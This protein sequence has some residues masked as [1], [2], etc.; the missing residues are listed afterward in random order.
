MPVVLSAV[1][2]AVV[3]EREQAQRRV[4][5]VAARRRLARRRA[6][7]PGRASVAGRR[8]RP[9]PAADGGGAGQGEAGG[10]GAWRGVRRGRPRSLLGGDRRRPAALVTRHEPAGALPTTGRAR[11]PV[12]RAPGERAGGLQQGAGAERHDPAVPVVRLLA[13]GV[14]AHGDRE[15]LSPALTVSSRGIDS[16]P[17][18]PS[19]VNASSPVSPSDS[20]HSPAEYCSGRTPMPMRFSGG[21]ARRTR[22]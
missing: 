11:E 15:L 6:R 19:M 1:G 20:A 8:G 16:A 10:V 7:R 17:A 9:G 3:R 4:G 5:R 21:C 14:D 2:P 22:R 13:R 12:G 18:M